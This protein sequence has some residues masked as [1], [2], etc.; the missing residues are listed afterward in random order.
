MSPALG[1]GLFLAGLVLLILVWLALRFMPRV[2]ATAQADAGAF[3]P[4][5]RS[6]SKDA[7]I[8]LQPGGRVDYV[9]V[10]ARAY[11]DLREN[12]PYDLERL[13]RRVRPSDEFL[14]LCV[15]PGT[16]RVTIGGKLVEIAS[17][18]V[19]GVIPIMLVS[20]RS[21]E[22][23]PVLESGSGASE[24][25]LRVVTEFSQSIAT[26]LDL[27]TT[28]QAIMEYVS[29]LV[30]SDA[31]ELKLW[32][33]E[34][35][36]LTS[37]RFQESNPPE[38]GAGLRTRSSQF[39]SLTDQLI[40]R[41]VPIFLPDAR[42]QAEL[43]AS[44]ELIAIQS[45][46]GIPLL[47]GGEL[48]GVF[49]AGQTGGGV[50]GSHDLDL[51]QLIAGQA[52]V[53]MRNAR[54]YE[55]EQK[56][57]AE[58]AGLANLNQSLGAIRDTQDL[59]SRLVE[60]VAPLFAAD[61]VGFLLFDE[62]KGVLEGQIP[63]H[64]LPSH[65]V[66]IY[67]ARILA[68][69]PA[70]E[71]LAGQ[72]PVLTPT[73]S[74]DETWRLL[75]LSDIAIAASLR[76]NALI[77][78]VSSGRMLGYL[79]V[80]HHTRGTSSFSLEEARLMNIVASQ[81]AAIIENALLVQQARA[82]AQR[83][84]A[85]R[86]IASLSSSTARLD[87]ILKYS[88]QELARLFSADAAAIFLLDEA[89]GD[90]RLD[91]E[92]TYGISEEISSS[93]IQLFVDDPTY[94][95]TVSGSQKPF[96]SGRL[97]TDSLVLPVYRP[98]ASALRMESAII[99]PLIVRDRCI[100]ELM[101]TSL[102]VDYYNSDDQQVV[103]T[104]AG[105]LATAVE[106]AG[107][108]AQ[109]DD[110]LRRRVDQLS[111]IARLSRELGASL[112]V[113]HVL[114]VIHSE[115]LRSIH[116]DCATVLLFE[117]DSLPSDQ[118]ISQIVGCEAV[119]EL[120]AIEQNVVQKGELQI[121][122]DFARD[123]TTPPHEGVRSAILAPITFQART[124]G[125]IS[126]HANKPNF[127]SAEVSEIVQTLVVQAG[128]ALSNA[129]RYQN[130]QER[131]EIMRR[132]SDT[133]LRLTDVSFNL[134]F[135]Q[136]LEQTLNVIAQGIRDSAPFRV[137]LVSAVEPETGLLRRVTAVGIPQET[138]NEILMR[139]QPLA[140]VQQLMKSEF[141][142]SHS[143]FIPADQTPVVSSDVHMVTLDLTS[144][145]VNS[146][147]AWNP[148]D[149]LLMPLED[150]AGQVVGLISL[151]DPV[152]G[153]RPDK[154]TIESLEVFAAQAALVIAQTFGGPIGGDHRTAAGRPARK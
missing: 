25:I 16:K 115:S 154:A 34:E 17:F 2:R 120:S 43:A 12:E 21:K 73:A 9:S 39:G 82:R 102:N 104:A 40:N 29:R 1:I 145:P 67:R 23:S 77:P 126:I 141:K 4:V 100:G 76:D 109:T 97:G 105:Q 147:N 118:R 94:P 35:Q 78:L 86:R 144:A 3:S 125:L 66:E 84:D 103:A 136:P 143:Y 124:I 116:S 26:S 71:V 70:E 54:L 122:E 7:V 49:E 63:F 107:L 11:F 10:A 52:A 119:H 131:S 48:V 151:D 28:V 93:F 50:F 47:A 152:N 42:S 139:K 89:R 44:G 24:E 101:L 114:Q 41:R 111:A 60:S 142:V 150:A 31:L 80:G 83:A 20:L 140:S 137:V 19:P 22:H 110:S 15:S 74:T 132:R 85:L 64:G 33:A 38:G 135:D 90:V 88:I 27:D 75:G 46:L 6:D 87:E 117:K 36:T 32:N 146:P 96:R 69:S 51:L 37:F 153:L 121:V 113:Q 30:P 98:L 148:D 129:Q 59:F 95:Y 92:S 5:E 112:D 81:A 123:G 56:R 65:L 57:G 58:L 53:A 91:R 128:I 99:V 149:F 45:Y 68:N 55:D 62:E 130:E 18:E 108:L 72:R 127:F 79:Q 14:D 13:A 138:L 8:L 133:L 134:G 61:I 106:S